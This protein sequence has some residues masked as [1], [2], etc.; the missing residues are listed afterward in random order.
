PAGSGAPSVEEREGNHPEEVT[1][2]SREADGE[3]E[4][5]EMESKDERSKCQD[6]N[7]LHGKL[8]EEELDPRIQ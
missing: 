2:D 7:S 5:T 6:D 3:S 1:D 4:E 8:T